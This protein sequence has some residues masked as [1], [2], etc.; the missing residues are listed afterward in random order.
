[1]YLELLKWLSLKPAY[2]NFR[3]GMRYMAKVMRNALHEHFPTVPEKE[4]LK[5]TTLTCGIFER[6]NVK[7]VKLS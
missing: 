5:V 4:T 2:N 7:T 1:M 6:M 3:Y